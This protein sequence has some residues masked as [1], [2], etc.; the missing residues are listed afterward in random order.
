VGLLLCYWQLQFDICLLKSMMM[1]MIFELM[2]NGNLTSQT[3]GRTDGQ[4]DNI[5]VVHRA[6]KIVTVHTDLAMT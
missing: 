2:P 5:S 6:V 4:T 1:M 3:D